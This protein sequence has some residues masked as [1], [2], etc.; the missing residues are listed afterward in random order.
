MGAP[1]EPGILCGMNALFHDARHTFQ[2]FGADKAPRLASSI[3][4]ATIF[5]LAPLLIVMIAILGFIIGV[6]NGG[7]GH[8]VAEDAIITQIQA[9]AG[10][11]AGAAVRG[12]IA[13]Q[14]D[15][16]RQSIVAQVVGWVAFIIA[17]SGLFSALQDALN[18]IWNVEATKGG[19]KHMLRE[20]FASFGMV[21][22]IGFVLVV[23][24][25][26]NALL[27]Y[28]SKQY[29]ASMIGIPA[30]LAVIDVVLNIA[31]IGFIFSAMFKVLPDVRLRWRDVLLG[32]YATAILFVIGEALIGLYI[33]KAG[34]VSAYG[35]AGSILV[36]LV[37]IYYSAMI[38]LL[39]A[40][41]TKVRSS[42]A[43]TE[44]PATIKG[45]VEAPAG[46]DPRSA[47]RD[48]QHR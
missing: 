32:G 22:V 28:L 14:F 6:Q 3:A 12:M 46:V 35:A 40:E 16:P 10:A 27:A 44:V 33:T 37:W 42:S 31:I 21:A 11:Q 36:A 29:F 48:V 9:H 30:V 39:G 43:A 47:S 8:H 18:T 13:A 17:A 5:A 20:R 23:A 34:V 15:K 2:A 38:L 45:T 26:A 41:F 25:G 4:Y 19:W 7:H 1:L 24:F